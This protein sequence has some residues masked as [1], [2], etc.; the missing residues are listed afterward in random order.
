LIS[1][2]ASKSNEKEKLNDDNYKEKL[3]LF[4]TTPSRKSKRN[5]LKSNDIII[6]TSENT[7]NTIKSMMKLINFY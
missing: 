2:L 3:H 7:V 6:A 5:F 4:C 1:I